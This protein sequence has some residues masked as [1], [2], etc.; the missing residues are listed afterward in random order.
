MSLGWLLY[1]F[2]LDMSSYFISSGNGAFLYD[3]FFLQSLFFPDGS[4]ACKGQ[5]Y[6]GS[7]II[8]GQ[9]DPILNGSLSVHLSVAIYT[10]AHIPVCTHV[11]IHTYMHINRIKSPIGGAGVYSH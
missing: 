8:L 10:Y 1:S 4:P 7:L 3:K 2:V 11:Y 9:V 6:I 5:I